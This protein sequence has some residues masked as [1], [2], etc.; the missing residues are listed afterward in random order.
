MVLEKLS[1]SLKN[2]LKKIAGSVLVDKKLI[3]ELV[4]EIQK[5]L[6]KAVPTD[7]LPS[8]GQ[9]NRSSCSGLKRSRAGKAKSRMV[10]L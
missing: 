3:E 4:K 2:T 10:L 7:R 9:M 5:A 6:L 8:I 1:E